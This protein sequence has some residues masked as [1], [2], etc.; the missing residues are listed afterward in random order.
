MFKKESLAIIIPA[1]KPE[2]LYKTLDSIAKQTVRNFHLYI[3]DDDSPYNLESIV[4]KFKDKITLTYVKFS[5]NLGSNDLV[6]HWNRCISLSREEKYIW[7]FSDD[8]IMGPK[9]VEEFFRTP[10]E[11]R[12]QCLYHFNLF[13]INHIVND[14][15]NFVIESTTN[16][17]LRLTAV[18][19]IKERY[20]NGL[21]CYAVEFVFT[22]EIYNEL[23]GFL[24][25]DLAWGSDILTWFKMASA[26]KY[27]IYTGNC[28]YDAS[29]F[30]RRS[31]VNLTP[32]RTPDIYY[33]KMKA[34]FD[35]AVF[36]K[37]ELERFPI[38]KKEKNSL[39]EFPLD[40]FMSCYNIL[41]FKKV[42]GLYFS[43]LKKFGPSLK[44]SKSMAYYVLRRVLYL[45]K[46]DT[47]K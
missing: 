42:I 4:D 6:A 12:D 7:L 25:F 39:L 15:K 30:W 24:K 20:I 43:Y 29:V 35:N 2:Y 28:Q 8:D 13:I 14:K 18:D 11:I 36:L 34:T 10:E 38:S 37:T 1:Y 9:C 31:S 17:P 47:R 45:L 27:G 23:G 16:F 46:V 33:R 3:G 40:A 41:P 26:L 22:R 5:E 21:K 32:K 19:Y 44:Y